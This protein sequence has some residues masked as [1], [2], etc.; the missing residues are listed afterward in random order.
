MGNNNAYK[1]KKVTIPAMVGEWVSAGKTDYCD[2]VK[3]SRTGVIAEQYHIPI[4]TRLSAQ[5]NEEI[6]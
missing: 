2:L 3:N 5:E 6:Y 1:E 4:E